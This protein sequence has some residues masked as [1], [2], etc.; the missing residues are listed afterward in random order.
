MDGKMRLGLFA[1]SEGHHVVSWR[2]PETVP[3]AG[4]RIEHYVEMAKTA[5]RGCFDMLFQADSQ[6][7]FGPDDPDI[8][9]RTNYTDVFEPLTLACAM[10]MVTS[11]IGLVCTAS[12]TYNDPYHVARYFASIDQISKGRAGWNLVT[13]SAASEALNFSFDSH[14][15]HAERYERAREF[16]EVVLGLWDSYDE[17]AFLGDKASGLYFD[18]AKLHFLNHKGKYFKV[19]GPLTCMR[20][21]QARPVMVQAG[22]SE[23]GLELAADTAEVLFSLTQDIVAA[24]A[25]YADLKKRVVERGRAPH[26]LLVMPGVLL[27]LGR[28]DREARDKF[29][30]VQSLIHPEHGI[31]VLSDLLNVDL[32]RHDI[33]G[34]L[35]DAPTTNTQQGRQQ[36]L[37]A[38]ARNENLS[39]R[40]V[41][42]RVVGARGHR[43]LCG[44]AKTAADS[45][46]E[47]FATGACDG[48]NIMPLTCPGGLNE[49]VDEVVPELQR[50]GLFRTKY[51]GSTLRENLALP[52]PVS[53]YAKAGAGAT[54]EA[55]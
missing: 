32:S 12:A 9:K 8:W 47:W 10:A 46:E 55:R 24:R 22:Q 2:H 16:A 6:S 5:E 4:H 34:P 30:Q 29:E 44:T 3:G 50:R 17:D 41:Y 42:T 51:E 53:R 20:S 45:L 21:P 31:A 52:R 1:L 11:R 7:T 26:S 36:L 19:R 15:P 18:P 13:S 14:V 23:A 48:F 40:E 39:I 49:I 43:I 54:V 33:D 37:Y 28:T 25:F 35:P 38:M 27:V